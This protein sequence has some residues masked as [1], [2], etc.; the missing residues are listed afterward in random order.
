MQQAIKATFILP[1][2]CNLVLPTANF[3]LLGIGHVRYQKCLTSRSCCSD[4]TFSKVPWACFPFSK[5]KRHW[6]LVLL[7]GVTS[8][9]AAPFVWQFLQVSRKWFLPLSIL[10]LGVFRRKGKGDY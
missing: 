4:M 6:A 8:P 9:P 10:P 2:D 7:N 1:P 5:Y 3:R